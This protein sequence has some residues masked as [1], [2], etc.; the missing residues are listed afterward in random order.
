MTTTSSSLCYPISTPK[1][2]WPEIPAAEQPFTGLLI[3]AA[4]TWSWWCLQRPILEPRLQKR[5]RQANAPANHLRA[6]LY[7]YCPPH[8]RGYGP[9]RPHHSRSLR[10]Y[11]PPC[12][13]PQFS[14]RNCLPPLRSPSS[15]RACPPRSRQPNSSSLRRHDYRFGASQRSTINKQTVNESSKCICLVGQLAPTSSSRQ[16]RPKQ[17]IGAKTPSI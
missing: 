15:L 17:L 13:R 3:V 5:R 11:S 12:R 7:R 2:S 10:L 9:P 1:A 8:C 16:R 6:W 14:P 4:P